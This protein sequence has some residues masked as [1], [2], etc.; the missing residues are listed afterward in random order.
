MC[1]ANNLLC[2]ID[3][4]LSR[5][6]SFR[7]DGSTTTIKARKLGGRRISQATTDAAKTE[8]P[9]RGLKRKIHLKTD[10]TLHGADPLKLNLGAEVGEEEET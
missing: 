4:A 6:E 5:T 3:D 2:L 9:R 7:S 8:M 1:S 10:C